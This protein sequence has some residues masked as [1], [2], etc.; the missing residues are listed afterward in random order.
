M[1]QKTKY[2]N[3]L[4]IRRG[5]NIGRKEKRQIFMHEKDLLDRLDFY[6]LFW[7]R[8]KP[9]G[10]GEKYIGAKTSE[11]WVHGPEFTT[12]DRKPLV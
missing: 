7:G 9:P 6:P 3:L 1:K 8:R 11:E 2:E 4:I 12:F 10:L 5:G